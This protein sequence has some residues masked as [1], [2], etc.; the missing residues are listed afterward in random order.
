M[1]TNSENDAAKEQ[2]ADSAARTDST[3][4]AEVSVVSSNSNLQPLSQESVKISAP[5]TPSDL[6]ASSDASNLVIPPPPA[7]VSLNEPASTTP[8]SDMITKQT[9]DSNP[10]GPATPRDPNGPVIPGIGPNAPVIPASIINPGSDLP[11]Q[12]TAENIYNVEPTN[13]DI[14]AMKPLVLKPAPETDPVRPEQIHPSQVNLLVTAAIHTMDTSI[15][16]PPVEPAVEQTQ[17]TGDPEADPGPPPAE[18]TEAE[19]S[20]ENETASDQQE[21]ESGLY[22][23][24]A[25]VT[26]ATNPATD[27]PGNIDFPTTNSEATNQAPAGN[28]TSDQQEPEPGLDLL[29]AT[30]AEVL[31]ETN[32]TENNGKVDLPP[33]SSEVINLAHAGNNTSEAVVNNSENSEDI[34]TTVNA[35]P[36]HPLQATPVKETVEEEETTP[37]SETKS[38][39]KKGQKK[40]RKHAQEEA[41]RN[42]PL[43]SDND[44][45]DCCV[46]PCQQAIQTGSS[47]PHQ[48]HSGTGQQESRKKP[49]SEAANWLQETT[50]RSCF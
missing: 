34:S 22:L 11:I 33:A 30:T 27:N 16:T 24:A 42:T 38:Q 32:G 15:H 40:E 8:S 31:E 43:K 9:T 17:A 21:P 44:L 46:T 13:L 2:V 10:N 50:L 37:S 20:Q 36:A 14:L 19:E 35:G 47:F 18:V 26:V 5:A 41:A 12:A 29:V 39:K 45:D 25:E 28:I 49:G 48:Q 4:Q 7:A 23:S 3:A 1:E 6:S